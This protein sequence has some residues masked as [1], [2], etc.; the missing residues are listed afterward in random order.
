[1]R[2]CCVQ[3]NKK[4]A[5]QVLRSP[6][7]KLLIFLEDECVSCCWTKGNVNLLLLLLLLLLLF[8]VRFCLPK[9]KG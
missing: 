5:I 3:T 1:M 6:E 7:S 2:H 4:G 8:C 9:R